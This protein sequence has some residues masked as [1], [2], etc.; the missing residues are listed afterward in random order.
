MESGEREGRS[1]VRRKMR[2]QAMRD[3]RAVIFEITQMTWKGTIGLRL[4]LCLMSQNRLRG[5]G[6]IKDR[7]RETP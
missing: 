7:D 4:D 5:L 2:G 1:K 6:S 3:C